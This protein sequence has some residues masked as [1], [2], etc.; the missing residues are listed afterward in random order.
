[1]KIQKEKIY[2]LLYEFVKIQRDI[3]FNRVKVIDNKDKLKE[4]ALNICKLIDFEDLD[5][6]TFN[7][8]SNKDVEVWS[9][10]DSIDYSISNDDRYYRIEFEARRTFP[11]DITGR[12][13]ILND[14]KSGYYGYRVYF[15]TIKLKKEYDNA[16]LINGV[17]I[18][19][20]LDGKTVKSKTIKINRNFITGYIYSLK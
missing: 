19:E 9:T 17:R 3:L 1:M 16:R 13:T 14:S 7:Q 5:I 18:D 12:I 2:C 11:S 20:Y 15:N 4:F 8:L 6:E 10:E